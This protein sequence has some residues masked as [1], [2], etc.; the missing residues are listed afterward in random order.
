MSGVQSFLR[1]LILGGSAVL[2][3]VAAGKAWGVSDIGEAPSCER[4][5]A[6][7][8][9]RHGLPP[10]LIRAV[11][12]TET[13][14]TVDGQYRAWPWAIN[15]AGQGHYPDNKA[16]ALARLRDL[17][18]RDMRSF[19]VGCMQINYRWHGQEFESLEAMLDPATNTDYAARYLARLRQRE[20]S[21][22]AAIRRYH[23]SDRR[24]GAAYLERV[25]SH[26]HRFASAGQAQP[27]ATPAA[28]VA[29]IGRVGVA[30][31]RDHRFSAQKPLVRLS[32][33]HVDQAPGADRLPAGRLP[34]R[35][36]PE[37]HAMR[38]GQ[39]TATRVRPDRLP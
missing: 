24:R 20:G 7:A 34:K 14:R 10:G 2:W 22:D 27:A 19:D 15:V 13:G 33:G 4:L 6:Q 37:G 12:L 36:D 3:L 31:A 21:W 16:E 38:Q 35:I 32:P 8:A 25:R 9:E 28:R 18:A 29:M 11:A 30:V 17:R 23:S 5:A 1:P 39:K 26:M